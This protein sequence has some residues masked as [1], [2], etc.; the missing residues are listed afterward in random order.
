MVN[1]I[2]TTVPESSYAVSYIH[3][4]GYEEVPQE[5]PGYNRQPETLRDRSL[6]AHESPSQRARSNAETTHVGVD[7]TGQTQ[8]ENFYLLLGATAGRA[9]GL[10]GNR[11]F[12]PNENDFGVIGEGLDQPER[13]D[14]R[15]RAPLHGARL[16][17][18]GGVGVPVSVGSALWRHRAVSGRTPLHAQRDFR[19]LNQGPES[20]RAF[21][22]DARAS[23]S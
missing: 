16:H 3:D 14:V 15:A 6:P 5:L 12:Q 11:G 2:N 23:R 7:I 17:A 13:A 21:A 20:V 9:E 10:A 19:G 22:T 8:T 1:L 4:D 18:E